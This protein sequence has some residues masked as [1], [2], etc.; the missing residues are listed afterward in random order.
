MQIV[1]A[2]PLQSAL[3]FFMYVLCS[4]FMLIAIEVISAF[5]FA[6]WLWNLARFLKRVWVE[7]V[8]IIVMVRKNNCHDT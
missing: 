7:M 4:I 6:R 3:V 2:G 1:F 5:V 8:I